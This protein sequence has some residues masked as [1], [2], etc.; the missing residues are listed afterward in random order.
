MPFRSLGNATDAPHACSIPHTLSELLRLSSVMTRLP[1][2]TAVSLA[3]ASYL[4]QG[5][6]AWAIQKRDTTTTMVPLKTL[7]MALSFDSSG[8]IVLPV[9]MVRYACS[10]RRLDPRSN[11]SLGCRT[12]SAE[13]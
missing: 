3:F 6:S 2:M 5:G 10:T 9:T 12:F 7:D 13:V 11:T 8:R 1:A 4:V